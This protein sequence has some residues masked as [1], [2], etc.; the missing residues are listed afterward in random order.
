MPFCPQ[1]GDISPLC[2]QCSQWEIRSSALRL[3]HAHQVSHPQDVAEYLAPTSEGL[4]W[5]YPQ[6][7][8]HSLLR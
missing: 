6:R 4:P 8:R 2:F 3:A 7:H 5:V 1:N